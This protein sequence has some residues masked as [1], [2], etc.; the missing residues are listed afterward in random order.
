[1]RATLAAAAALAMCAAPAVAQDDFRW[2]HGG[3]YAGITAGYSSAVLQTQ[4]PI[5][6]A[7][8]GLMGGVYGGYGVQGK[9]G[10]YI[11][12]EMDG[13]AKDITWRATDG[14]GTTVQASGQWLASGRLRVGQAFGPMLVYATGGA[15]LSDQKISVTGLGSDTEWRYGWVFGG[16]I[17]GMVGKVMTLRLEALRYDFPD[18]AFWLNGATDKIGTQ[19]T[20]VRVGLGFKLQ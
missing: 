19:E 17:E 8:S 14:A 1:M 7:A 2:N 20:V 4:D 12:F 18:K 13:V 6:W 16:G 10:L 15:A 3:T 5:D 11:G 9:S